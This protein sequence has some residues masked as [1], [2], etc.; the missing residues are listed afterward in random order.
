MALMYKILTTKYISMVLFDS[1][2]SSLKE[3]SDASILHVIG[4]STV[5]AVATTAMTYPLDLIHTRMSA[6]MSSKP[7]L[8]ALDGKENKTVKYKLYSSVKDCL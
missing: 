2:L 4:A 1:Y 5:V 6:D 3:R 8:L 7:P